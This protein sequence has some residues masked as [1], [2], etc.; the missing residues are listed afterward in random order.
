MYGNQHVSYQFLDPTGNP[1]SGK[2]T[3][4]ESE[5]SGEIVTVLFDPNKPRRN[6]LYPPG[7]A[8]LAK[9]R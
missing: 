6:A 8:R 9:P 5:V 7:L 2:T 3:S 4:T 1:V